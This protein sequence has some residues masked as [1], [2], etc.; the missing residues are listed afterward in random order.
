MHP[1]YAVCK[2]RP[3]TQR[4]PST[5]I[6]TIDSL[7]SFSAPKYSP[8]HNEYSGISTPSP[9][10]VQFSN[11]QPTHRRHEGKCR[12][13]CHAKNYTA[14]HAD[15]VLMHLMLLHMQALIANSWSSRAHTSYA[16]A[17]ANDAATKEFAF[18]LWQEALDQWPY[19]FYEPIPKMSKACIP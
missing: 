6:K 16:N 13:F 11:T 1:H 19:C 12:T 2:K 3:R 9:A 18:G 4:K 10:A 5:D 8:A 17:S 14:I 15:A 7:Q